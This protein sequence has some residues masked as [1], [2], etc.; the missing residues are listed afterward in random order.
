MI[1]IEKTGK[2]LSLIVF[3]CITHVYGQK[4]D[5]KSYGIEDGLAFQEVTAVF[6]DMNGNLWLQSSAENISMFDGYRFK[7]Y[8]SSETGIN[9]FIHFSHANEQGLWISEGNNCSR[10]FDGRWEILPKLDSIV[11]FQFNGNKVFGC[12]SNFGLYEY[13]PNISSFKNRHELKNARVFRQKYDGSRWVFDKSGQYII[14]HTKD[15]DDIL[16]ITIYQK[17]ESNTSINFKDANFSDLG[18]GYLLIKENKKQQPLIFYKGK[19]HVLKNTLIEFPE[20]LENYHFHS[21]TLSNDGEEVSIMHQ[22]PNQDGMLYCASIDLSEFSIVYNKVVPIPSVIDFEKDKFGRYWIASHTGLHRINYNIEEYNAELIATLSSP[23]A[24]IQDSEGRMWF[25]GYKTG[26]SSYYNQK[27]RAID[28]KDASRNSF[29]PG[30]FKTRYGEIMFFNSAN[31]ILGIKGEQVE[32]YKLYEDGINLNTTGY[33]I[34]SLENGKIVLGLY[35]RGLGIVDRIVDD[36]IHLRVIDEKKGIKLENALTIAED[37]NNRIWVGR[38]SKGIAAYHPESDTA[39]TWI[40]NTQDDNTIGA[41][42]MEIDNRG[43]LWMGAHNGLYLLRN[44]HAYDISKLDLFDKCE[45]IALP[46]GDNSMVTITKQ[47]DNF[48]IIGNTG[49]VSFLELDYFFRTGAP[50]IFQLVFG[51]DLS[52]NGC[53]QNAINID[54]ENNLWI[55]T[56]SGVLKI[57]LENLVFD[58]IQNELVL[59]EATSGAEDIK[60]TKNKL[61]I[62]TYNRNFN[63]G[64]NT[65]GYNSLYNNIFLESILTDRAGDTLVKKLSQRDMHFKQDL[66]SPGSYSLEI[67]ARKNG[68]EIDRK[69]YAIIVPLTLSENPIFWV[70]LISFILLLAFGS[71]LLKMRKDKLLLSQELQ[72]NSLK[73]E[74]E[75]LKIQSIINSFNPH[76]INNSL[77][78]AQSRY[79]KD[80]DL[81]LLIGKLS[82]NIRYIFKNTLTGQA[83]HA[84]YDE[85]KLVN[86]YISIQKLRFN[87]SFEFRIKNEELIEENKNIKLIIMQLQIHVE[88]AIEHGLRNRKD[89]SFVELELLDLGSYWQ[90]NIVDDGVGISRSKKVDSKGTQS[91]TKMLEELYHIFNQNN[92]EQIVCTYEDNIFSDLTGETYGTRISIKLPK[93]YSY[94]L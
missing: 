28:F 73:N 60:Q 70:S 76:F 62:P 45:H 19:V 65:L 69:S 20:T 67:K 94:E 59:T 13:D 38:S 21:S 22:D 56:H 6:F 9:S 93:V 64:F 30:A 48:L 55:G 88:N 75:H 81:V 18:R 34:D 7:H 68:I 44:P 11:R 24:V 39:Y 8:A 66:I 42:S 12:D 33:F 2:I 86:N 26:L 43:N 89:S 90:F 41:I 35:R 47:Y 87:N 46:D 32:F 53:E 29:L 50:R 71:Y 52:G 74:K 37:L 14:F 49:S 63:L 72:L 16:N 25:T 61:F 85:L 3:L 17:N 23:S 51:E 79:R 83:V 40:R 54:S 58:T 1:K 15:D 80:K 84:L 91:G 4:P 82:E 10:F 78:W 27:A 57:D 5:I 36:S 92:R 31:E 77:H